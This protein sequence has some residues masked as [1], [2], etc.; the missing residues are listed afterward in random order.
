MRA[1]SEP[2]F[3]RAR[4]LLA[5]GCTGVALGCL[6]GSGA[7]V[8]GALTAPSSTGVALQLATLA[9]ALPLMVVI[10]AAVAFPLAGLLVVFLTALA[11]RWSA[12]DHSAAWVVA[13]VLLSF[14][15]AWAVQNFDAPNTPFQFTWLSAAFLAIGAVSAAVAWSFRRRRP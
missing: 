3:T 11:R 10:G 8:W 9:T 4:A 2:P 14:P 6:L 13:G 5:G 15:V 7:I 12:F 1:L